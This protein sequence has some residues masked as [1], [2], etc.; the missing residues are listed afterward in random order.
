[1]M[2]SR[3]TAT[4]ESRSAGEVPMILINGTCRSRKYW[5]RSEG[6]MV[7]TNS[8][9]SREGEI[10]DRLQVDAGPRAG[11]ASRIKSASA[12]GQVNRAWRAGKGAMWITG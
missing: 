9:P 4:E 2:V 10:A 8:L 12:C 11:V 6:V 7:T 5:L 1:M 3:V